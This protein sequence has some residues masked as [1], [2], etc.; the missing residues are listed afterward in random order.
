MN[1]LKTAIYLM[2]CFPGSFINHKGEFIAN[3]VSNVYFSYEN[4]ENDVD[5]KAK[6]LEYLSRAASK[7]QPYDTDRANQRY[8]KQM[9]DGINRFLNTNF[10]HE[11]MDTIYTYLGN[12]CNHARTLKF[13]ESGYRVDLLPFAEEEG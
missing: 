6:V 13:I 3:R 12:R 4:C 1:D 2:S 10:S 7:G 8:Q 11:D 5:V 9:L